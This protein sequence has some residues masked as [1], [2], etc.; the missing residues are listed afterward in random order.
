MRGINNPFLSPYLL[1]GV[2]TKNGFESK[3]FD[4]NKMFCHFLK[5]EDFTN[6]DCYKEYEIDEFIE[7]ISD[8][9]ISLNP[10]MIGF[11]MMSITSYIF[12]KKI[13]KVI[14]E[15]KKSVIISIGGPGSESCSKE[16]L[17]NGW[18]DFYV[19]GDGE[20][21]ILKILQGRYKNSDVRS[22][23][24][25]NK[26]PFA[27]F[28]ELENCSIL[29]IQGSRGCI[30]K[31]TFCNKNN[32]FDDFRQRDGRLIA[33][34]MI[35]QNDRYKTNTFSIIDNA[36]NISKKN[37]HKMCNMI[38]SF[39]KDDVPFKWFSHAISKLNF[40]ADLLKKSGCYKLMVGIESGS[41][42][43]LDHMRKN[44]RIEDSLHFIEKCVESNINL[45]LYF[46][47]GYPTET[48]EDFLKTL[49]LIDL[50]KSKYDKNIEFRVVYP[51]IIYKDSK[52]H[53]DDSIIFG[54]EQFGF[55]ENW[56]F[57]DN[58]KELR[59]KRYEIIKERI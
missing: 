39:Y 55:F 42:R 23:V 52:L 34:E 19:K 29:P 11:S 10:I 51:I 1:K 58:N 36:V 4:L 35:Y 47:V 14:K 44:I 17:N 50:I 24:D 22:I 25:I 18:I 37:L 40:D 5:K 27:D 6:E 48:D 32:L 13:C 33:S 28:S 3:T 8:Y 9:F 15:K 49:D 2:L 12:T 26:T 43:V 53:K 41:Q 7:I 30:G 54:K 59:M 20:E 16:F 31:C 45:K 38:L 56:I 46:T 21:S 57:G